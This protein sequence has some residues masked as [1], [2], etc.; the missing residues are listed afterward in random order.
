MKWLRFFCLALIFPL[1]LFSQNSLE[2]KDIKKW[3]HRLFEYHVEQKK[4]SSQQ[5]RRFVKLYVG[6]FDKEKTYFL[7]DEVL[8]YFNV[9]ENQANEMI[10]RL[11]GED[12]SDFMQINAILARSVERAR[13]NRNLLKESILHEADMNG[14]VLR[15]EW[16]SFA[17]NEKDLQ[18]RQRIELRRLFLNYKRKMESASREREEKALRMI[19]K[20][21]VRA[22]NRYIEK[23]EHEFSL[24]ILKA[25]AKSLDAHSA[26]FSP[27]EAFEMRMSLEKQFEG[28]G[29]ILT[30][31][32]D[33]AMVTDLIK[34]SPAQRSGKIQIRD[35]I[36]EI[37]GENVLDL[38]FE[39][40]LEK[41]KRKNGECVSLGLSRFS[42]EKRE[43]LP[44][45]H[46]TLKPEPI[47]M[48]EE[49]LRS[50]FEPFGNGIIG[51]IT[52]TSFY[53]NS[54]GVT[55]EGDLKKAIDDLRKKGNLLGL[56]LDLRENSG[57]FLN[58]AVKV[59]SLFLSNGIVVISKYSK[60]ECRY[61]RNTEGKPYFSGPLIL[62]TSKLSASASEIVAQALQDYGVALIVGD[63]RT[64]GKGTIQYQTVTN[65]KAEAYFKVTVGKYYTVSGKSTQIEGVKADV[66]LPTEFSI[67]HLG[68]RYL[69]YPLAPDYISS[70]YIDPL[71]D[72]DQKTKRWFEKNYMP[73]LQPYVTFW[74][75][76]ANILQ[77]NSAFRQSKDSNFQL[78]LKKQEM[79]RES[80]STEDLKN[81]GVE[82][83]QMQEGVHILKDMILLEAERSPSSKPLQKSLSSSH[84]KN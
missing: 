10:A 20:K 14:P 29:V 50:S 51:K 31:S 63:E 48:E 70:L 60:G 64:F 79:V 28:L 8:S 7:E 4:F 68:E 47:S 52:L 71:Y 32:V 36:A 53:E 45:W 44:S 34:G 25:F 26:F 27:E 3:T 39:E 55:C 5:M 43:Y 54:D 19:E 77:E 1:L 35:L 38:S 6:Q 22:E 33:G 21:L 41:L 57:G 82:N 80:Q 59:A 37:D 15:S 56:I 65:D 74:Q 75:K 11:E 2:I 81:Y 78:F 61:L 42:V 73:H 62:L 9:T 18:E 12:Y 67:Y 16:S 84:K 83:L 66:L 40:V 46:V 13:K 23:N 76:H 72:L 30:E 69:E 17:K 24:N 58:Q 49:K